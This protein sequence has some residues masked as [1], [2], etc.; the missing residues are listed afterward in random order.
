MAARFI[1]AGVCLLLVLTTIQTPAKDNDGVVALGQRA[2]GPLASRERAGAG[3][4]LVGLYTDLCL[5]RFPDEAKL[6]AAVRERGMTALGPEAVKQ[7]LHDDPGRGWTARTAA[8]SYV[9]TIENP[10][11]HACAVRRLDAAP[12]SFRDTYQRAVT[13]WAAA[14]GRGS[15]RDYPPMNRTGD[16]MTINATMSGVPGPNGKPVETFMAFV[17][18]YDNGRIETRLVHQFPP[19]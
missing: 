17:T 5:N 15:L 13:T 4:E 7:Y 11:Y 18:T 9:V 19:R 12:P 14:Q 1:L 6:A 8:G 10:P 2:D 16:G 3:A